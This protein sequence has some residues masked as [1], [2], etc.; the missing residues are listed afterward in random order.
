[1]ILSNRCAEDG[2]EFPALLLRIDEV[3]V[4][5]RVVVVD[6]PGGGEEELMFSVLG[7]LINYSLII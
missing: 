4:V 7:V 2:K 3:V 1:M 6:A 5:G